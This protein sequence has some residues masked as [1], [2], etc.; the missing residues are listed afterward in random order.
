[1]PKKF[2]PLTFKKIHLRDVNQHLR[3]GNVKCLCQKNSRQKK[4]TSMHTDT[5]YKFSSSY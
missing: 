3:K 5:N 1:M 4:H 2:T